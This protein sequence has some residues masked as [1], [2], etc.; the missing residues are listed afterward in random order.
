MRFY[1]TDHK[2]GVVKRRN[3]FE[4]IEMEPGKAL[5]Q[6]NQQL[7]K[8]KYHN[9]TVVLEEITQLELAFLSDIISI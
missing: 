5:F 6:V 2:R 3:Y 7:F 1:T 8:V 9:K 4:A